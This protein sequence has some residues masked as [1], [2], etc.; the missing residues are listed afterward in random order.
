MGRSKA[1]V[2]ENNDIYL[3]S[4]SGARKLYWGGPD[5]SNLPEQKKLLLKKKIHSFKKGGKITTPGVKGKDQ[6]K[7]GAKGAKGGKK[8]K[9]QKK[10]AENGTEPKQNGGLK[11]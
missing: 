11:E 9:G 1:Y 8:P 5:F 6:K 2:T 3:S 10:T 4:K 7:K